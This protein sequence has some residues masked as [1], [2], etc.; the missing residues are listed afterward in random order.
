MG[1]HHSGVQSAFRYLQAHLTNYFAI[2]IFFVFAVTQPKMAES[3]QN[4]VT[5]PAYQKS[6]F[7]LNFSSFGLQMAE[8]IKKLLIVFATYLKS[9]SHPQKIEIFWFSQPFEC[10]MS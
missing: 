7:T 3:V 4:K 6:I 8:K 1:T 5:Q 10:Q 9:V 2:L